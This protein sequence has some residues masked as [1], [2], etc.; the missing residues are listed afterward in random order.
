MTQT[1]SVVI[2][3]FNRE[4]VITRA[5][6][7]AIGQTVQPLELI[8]VDD[9]STD[10]TCAAVD[11]MKAQDARIRLIRSEKNEGAAA[12]R[13]RGVLSARGDFVAFLDSDDEWLPSHL[14]RKLSLAWENPDVALL[15]G[16]FYVHDGRRT[17]LQACRPICGDACEYL[18]L[19]CG[20]LRTS[21]FVAHRERFI[22]VMFDRSLRK[23]QDWD[24]AINLMQRYEIMVDETPTAVLH[25]NSADR[26]SARLDHEASKRFYAKNEAQISRY[27]KVLFGAI[28]LQRTF[29]AERESKNYYDFLHI[30]SDIDP[31]A[32]HFLRRVAPFLYVPRFGGRIFLWAVRQ[33]VRRFRIRA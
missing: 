33:Y 4:D 32:Y 20:G 30:V 7:S 14:Q 18:F 19:G 5:I 17:W 26:L 3:A 25:T 6:D 29:A 12:A 23:H 11:R 31:N 24:L 2:A 9:G 22:E 28:M 8:V 27:G 1:V 10:G 16:A 13:N 21:T 15:F